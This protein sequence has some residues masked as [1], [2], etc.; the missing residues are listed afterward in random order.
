MATTPPVPIYNQGPSVTH[1]NLPPQYDP[2]A[3]YK[4]PPSTG[5]VDIQGDNVT[6]GGFYDRW[7]ANRLPP[8]PRTVLQP[9]GGQMPIGVKPLP[10]PRVRLGLVGG[11][12]GG[13]RFSGPDYDDTGGLFVT[14]PDGKPHE[15]PGGDPRMR[16][17]SYDQRGGPER[18]WGEDYGFP[19]SGP[20]MRPP[21]GFG[22]GP[23]KEMGLGG[24]EVGGGQVFGGGPSQFNA[25]GEAA[26]GNWGGGEMSPEEEEYY[27]QQMAHNSGMQ[28]QGG[29]PGVPPQQGQVGGGRAPLRPGMQYRPGG[30]QRPTGGVMQAMIPHEQG[31]VPPVQQMPVQGQQSWRDNMRPGFYGAW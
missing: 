14:G 8:R 13:G 6:N 26:R 17:G 15:V 2:N 20:I 31:Q 30:G 9:G 27:R 22:Y 23:G 10:D 1:R 21:G 3:A 24:Q 29:Q 4:V 5:G 16:R 7:R 19:G 25:K 12:Q 11:Y 18:G 28:P